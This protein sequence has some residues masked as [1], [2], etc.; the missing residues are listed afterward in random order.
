MII[1][2]YL[3]G[4][5]LFAKINEIES[6]T[7]FNDL[8]VAIIDKMFVAMYSKATCNSMCD[9]MTVDEWAQFFAKQFVPRWNKLYEIKSMEYNPLSYEST[10]EETRSKTY[11]DEN[12][13]EQHNVSAYNEEDYSKDTQDLTTISHSGDS[14]TVSKTSKHNLSN[15]FNSQ[16]N[17][18]NWLR[19]TLVFDI[20]FVDVKEMLAISIYEQ[21]EN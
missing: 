10:D 6:V 8:D 17:Y 4:K 13:A 7:C 11:G 5:T 9:I 18:F 3:D 19:K 16:L 21:E 1:S 20:M 14:E 15:G 2:E 12:R